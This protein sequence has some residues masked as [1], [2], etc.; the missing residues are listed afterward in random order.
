[1]YAECS[2]STVRIGI[3][4]MSKG[5]LLCTVAGGTDSVR[6]GTFRIRRGHAGPYRRVVMGHIGCYTYSWLITLSQAQFPIGADISSTPTTSKC[7]S[8]SVFVSTFCLVYN[9]RC[10]HF[11]TSNILYLQLFSNP[12][13]LLFTA[14]YV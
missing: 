9:S 2:R 13:P 6:C 12:R 1:M 10:D 3:G 14:V 4:F 5:T 7:A 11:G 8:C